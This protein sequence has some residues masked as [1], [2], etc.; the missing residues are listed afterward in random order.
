MVDKKGLRGMWEKKMVEQ[1][2]R[3]KPRKINPIKGSLKK[4]EE[5]QER[6]QEKE[7]GNFRRFLG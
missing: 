1:G 2:Y 5:I 7:I 3:L 6:F 4:Q